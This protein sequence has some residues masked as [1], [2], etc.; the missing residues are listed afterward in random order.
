MNS[1][2]KITAESS[3]IHV[4]ATVC[5]LD[6]NGRDK[7]IKCSNMHS[8]RRSLLADCTN[9]HGT[10]AKAPSLFSSEE[11]AALDS[12]R[13]VNVT[14][15]GFKSESECDDIGHMYSGFRTH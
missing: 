3:E 9:T 13:G 4:V 12:N 7:M 1:G 2:T 11:P 6:L 8:E 15:C 5:A 14:Q 10:T